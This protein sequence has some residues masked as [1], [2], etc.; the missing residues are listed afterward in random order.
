MRRVENHSEVARILTQ[1][2]EEYE[3]AQRGLAGLSQGTPQHAFIT[4]RMEN[5]GKLHE[6]LQG[7][8][9]EDIAIQLITAELDEVG[10]GTQDKA[11]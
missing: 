4:A 1:I 2:R 3:A 6:K 8:T 11:L 7:L 5:M 10:S 9:G